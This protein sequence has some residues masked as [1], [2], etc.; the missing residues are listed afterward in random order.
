MS[1]SA[2]ST[3]TEPLKRTLR[4]AKLPACCQGRT[5]IAAQLPTQTS[6]WQ[7]L[8]TCTLSQMRCPL[9]QEAEQGRHCN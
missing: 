4:T 2:A 3:T 5:C 1:R 7:M 9:L 6:V 8:A